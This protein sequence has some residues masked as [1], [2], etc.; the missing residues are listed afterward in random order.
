VTLENLKVRGLT[1]LGSFS[2][3]SSY[4][5]LEK[6]KNRDVGV[7]RGI[8]LFLKRTQKV[9]SIITGNG[10]D[11]TPALAALLAKEGKAIL[12]IGMDFGQKHESGLVAFIREEVKEPDI[13]KKDGYDFLSAGG[14]TKF[15]AEFLK[16]PHFLAFLEKKK[17]EY[18]LVILSSPTLACSSESKS[19]SLFSDD[20]ILTL[21]REAADKLMPYIVWEEAD[22]ERTLGFVSS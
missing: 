18:D 11:Y 12:L 17:K 14:E 5:S 4:K 6:V 15:G 8:T 19:F 21:D 2:G 16:H 9:V 13:Q 1:T 20:I 7:L 22:P 10:D 3:R